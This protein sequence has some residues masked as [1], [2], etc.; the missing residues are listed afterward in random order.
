[1]EDVFNALDV[2]IRLL[3]GIRTRPELAGM[4]GYIYIYIYIYIN[5]FDL[6]LFYLFNGKVCFYDEIDFYR[7]HLQYTRVFVV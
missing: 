7:S 4:I 2:D 6:L 5:K 1:M 3:C